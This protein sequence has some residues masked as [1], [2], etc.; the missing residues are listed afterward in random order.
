MLQE[1]QPDGRILDAIDSFFPE[2]DGAALAAYGHPV[3]TEGDP[4]GGPG[5]GQGHPLV[6]T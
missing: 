3:G 5:G 6:P 1:G 2:G 4:W